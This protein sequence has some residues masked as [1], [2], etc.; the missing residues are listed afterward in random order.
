MFYRHIARVAAMIVPI[1]FKRNKY[2]P[3]WE[4]PLFLAGFY[5][6]HQGRKTTLASTQNWGAIDYFIGMDPQFA[7]VCHCCNNT[8]EWII[9][10][11]R[12]DKEEI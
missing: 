12:S 11:I 4:T 5:W 2:V 6:M 3:E 7:G 8:K 1:G 10:Q 9:L